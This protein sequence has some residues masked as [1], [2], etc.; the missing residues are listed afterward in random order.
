M[1]RHFLTRLRRAVQRP[2]ILQVAALCLRQAS[3]KTEVLLIKSLDSGR[4][5]I[6]KGWPMKGRTLAQAAEI[7]AWEEAGVR[8]QISPDA[9]GTYYYPKRRGSGVAQPCDVHVFTLVVQ[10][11]AADFPEA[12]QRHRAWFSAASAA[13]RLADPELA[14]LLR[15][16]AP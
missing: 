5:I 1:I 9:V 13:A 8:G 4:W 14:A 3:G 2:P 15:R 6:P 11:E 16:L 12:A 7:E 10:S